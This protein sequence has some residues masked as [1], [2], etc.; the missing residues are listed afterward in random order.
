MKITR[1]QIKKIIREAV[2]SE[3]RNVTWPFKEIGD[4]FQER[5]FKVIKARA[6]DDRGI[7]LFQMPI[8]IEGGTS[9]LGYY[10]DVKYEYGIF[11]FLWFLRTKASPSSRQ[12]I[13]VMKPGGGQPR[14]EVDYVPADLK[15]V[16][17]E[18]DYEISVHESEGIHPFDLDLQKSK[19]A[20]TGA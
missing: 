5:G 9:D 19:F 3:A 10:V 17:D 2:I 7:A 1:S 11:Y 16:M 14:W 18:I 15:I 4:Y 13:K 6:G 20:F 12:R 8:S